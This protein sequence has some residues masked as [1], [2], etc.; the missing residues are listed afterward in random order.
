MSDF[1]DEEGVDE[2]VLENDEDDEDLDEEEVSG[3]S[4]YMMIACF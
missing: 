1:D 3:K 2:P 4:E